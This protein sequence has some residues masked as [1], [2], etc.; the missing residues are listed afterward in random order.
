MT[1]SKSMNKCV[2]L[3]NQGG[4]K[5]FGRGWGSSVDCVCEQAEGMKLA[6]PLFALNAGA[7]YLLAEG[8]T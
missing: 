3:S 7:V 2:C 6:L 1:F 5:F 4:V 8:R